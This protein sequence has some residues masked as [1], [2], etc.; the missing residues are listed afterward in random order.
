MTTGFMVFS[1]WG[2]FVQL[3]ITN[4]GVELTTTKLP[5]ES[6]VLSKIVIEFSCY[7]KHVSNLVLL[8]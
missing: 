2:I 7:R 1:A 8:K 3:L 4:L 6:S 5:A